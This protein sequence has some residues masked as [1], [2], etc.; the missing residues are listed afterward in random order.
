MVNICNV[1]LRLCDWDWKMADL[2]LPKWVGS[3]MHWQLCQIQVVY[4]WKPDSLIHFKILMSVLWKKITQ[5]NCIAK[6]KLQTSEVLPLLVHVFFALENG[7][8]CNL[9]NKAKSGK[10]HFLVLCVNLRWIGSFWRNSWSCPL[11]WA[12][13]VSLWRGEVRVQGFQSE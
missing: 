8:S 6:S 2:T 3:E 12:L 10:G 4:P 5:D 11:Q 7:F 1:H 9:S 13:S